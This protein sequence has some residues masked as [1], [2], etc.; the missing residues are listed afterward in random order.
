M[1]L[2]KH[3][4]VVM[5]KLQSVCCFNALAVTCCTL[6]LAISIPLQELRMFRGICYTAPTVLVYTKA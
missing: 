2:K 5:P 3:T 4:V 1:L 6:P